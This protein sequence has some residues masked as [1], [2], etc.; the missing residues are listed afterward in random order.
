MGTSN[1]KKT[2]SDLISELRQPIRLEQI[3]EEP[4]STQNGERD[5]TFDVLKGLAILFVITGH[6]EI[7]VLYSFIHSFHMPLFFFISGFFLR[8][9]PLREE[10]S[11]SFKRL[12]VPYIFTAFCICIIAFCKDLSNYT[13][14]DGSHTQFTIIKYLFGFRGQIGP[15]WIIGSISVLWFI[16]AMFWTRTIAVILIGKIKSII[17]LCFIFLFLGLWGIYLE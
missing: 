5:E 7:G 8:L 2:F 9:R 17:I 15:S 6:C 14:S 16:L 1:L 13:W 12:I 4:K 11:L 10:I 3:S